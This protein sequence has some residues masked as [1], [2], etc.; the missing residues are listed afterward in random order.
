MSDIVVWGGLAWL[1]LGLVAWLATTIVE[2]G[3]LERHGPRRKHPD[4]RRAAFS[5]L[6]MWVLGP[7]AWIIAFLAWRETRR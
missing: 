5:A 3:R 1:V 6:L 4:Y 7:F 2:G